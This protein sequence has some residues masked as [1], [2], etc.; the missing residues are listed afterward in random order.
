DDAP[1]DISQ[2][3]A[4]AGHWHRPGPGESHFGPVP[5]IVGEMPAPR[6][7]VVSW[8]TPFPNVDGLDRHEAMPVALVELDRPSSRS[9]PPWPR[10]GDLARRAERDGT[11]A[12]SAA[13]LTDAEIATH[14][15]VTVDRLPWSH[16]YD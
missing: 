4:P 11:L 6:R 14:V 5:F 2:T 13:P 7:T 1:W 9:P 12:L 8:R 10:A 16:A 15:I 3:T